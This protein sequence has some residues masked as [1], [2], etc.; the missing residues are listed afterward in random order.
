MVPV[1][2]LS[3]GD[4]VL[5]MD[6]GPQPLRWIGNREVEA[7]GKM[8]PVLIE[9][10]AI[11][12]H[13]AL[14]VSPQ[15]RVLMRDP[16]AALLFGEEE[17]LV[18]ARDLVNGS[19]IR[20]VEGGT[21]TYHHILFDRHQVVYSEGLPTESFHPGPQ[22]TKQFD[23]EVLEEICTL[24]PELTPETGM[25]HGPAARLSLKSFEARLLAEAAA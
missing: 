6:E 23:P 12:E 1:E 20:H 5:T 4:M 14:M 13:D 22:A 9:A 10:N 7:T 19:T 11:G 17:V 18:K 16:L 2:D 8:A 24:F 3:V 25:N 15:H 21:V